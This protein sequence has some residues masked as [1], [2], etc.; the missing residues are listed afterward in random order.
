MNAK[1][2][3]SKRYGVLSNAD[4]AHIDWVEDQFGTEIAYDLVMAV[5]GYAIYGKAEPLHGVT[6]SLLDERKPSLD[7]RRAENAAVLA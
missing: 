5:L 6:V 1:N 3:Y 7:A 2:T 4:M